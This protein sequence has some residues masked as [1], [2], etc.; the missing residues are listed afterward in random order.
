MAFKIADGYVEV[1][2]K[3]NQASFRR[4]ATKAATGHGHAAGNAFATAF[5]HMAHRRFKKLTGFF[6]DPI[7]AMSSALSAI[8]GPS[9]RAGI[10]GSLVGLVP[11]VGK[12]A[13]AL[14]ASL[15]P[16]MVS[17]GSVIG[18]VRLMLGK[19]DKSIKG[20][21]MKA[22]DGMAGEM[23]KLA[24]EAAKPGLNEFFEGVVHNGPIFE[25]HIQRI[26]TS[27]GRA[28]GEVGHLLGDASFSV[29]LDKLLTSAARGT[30]SWTSAL[31]DAVDIIV[32]LGAAAGPIFEK[33]ASRLATIVE[34]FRKFLDLRSLTGELQE[35]LRRAAAELDRWGR[36]F[37]NIIIG[38]FNLFAGGAGPMTRFA[39][40]IEKVT[41]SFRKWTESSENVEKVRKVLQWLVD[42]VGD[43]FRIAASAL[44]IASGL[45]AIGVAIEGINW[46]QWVAT[47][48]PVGLLLTGIGLAIA[49]MAG[50][51]MLAYNNSE[52]FRAKVAEL[53]SQVQERLLPVLKEWG[54][55]LKEEG[56][57]A[58]E[59]FA[60]E[61]MSK[62]IGQFDHLMDKY[63]ENKE[64]IQELRQVLLDLEP[65]FAFI[66]SSI[67]E[68]V[69]GAIGQ[70]IT[71]LGWLGRA[72]ALI[73]EP[74][75][76]AASV[77]VK[78]LGFMYNT[79]SIVAQRIADVFGLLPGPLGAPFRAASKAIAKHR[80]AV[81]KELNR[82]QARINALHGKTVTIRVQQSWSQMWMPSSNIRMS[83]PGGRGGLASGGILGAQGML[84]GGIS[85]RRS[86]LVGEQGPEMVELPFGS[87]VISAGQTRT[88]LSKGGGGGGPMVLEIRSGGSRLDD[89]L[90]Q[91]LQKSIRSRGGNVQTVLGT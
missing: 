43:F 27:V 88:A 20:Q 54:T 57:P 65:V 74:F 50:S 59:K 77:V 90:V 36:I 71:I 61:T 31:D 70:V 80:A 58:L 3:V 41:A 33:M 81:N 14:S 46:F 87:R 55:W 5:G 6:M 30:A 79:A 37:N 53:G 2:G 21:T 67:V 24:R 76:N 17:F 18:V 48:G 75:L 10:L 25:R 35:G 38:L 26:A 19:L 68:E 83:T 49:A 91:V 78:A 56:G 1:H 29:K 15:I 69:G 13:T 8:R 39:E 86:I 45:K 22:L 12:A 60:N 7:H 47:M 42:H 66:G 72:I 32:T 34:R 63:E 9:Q 52:T 51:F 89:L 28:F 11:S 64:G 82:I 85:G 73:K 84:T 62:I 40:N 16:A 4:A 23:K 44:V